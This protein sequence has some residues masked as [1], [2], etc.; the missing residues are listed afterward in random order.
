MNKY[1]TQKVLPQRSLK[2]NF[3]KILFYFKFYFCLFFKLRGKLFNQN[4]LSQQTF[5][6]VS[7]R[8]FWIL[9]YSSSFAIVLDLLFGF[10]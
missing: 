10:C 1:N 7:P 3:K 9:E 6:W 4:T 2:M 5:E 8:N